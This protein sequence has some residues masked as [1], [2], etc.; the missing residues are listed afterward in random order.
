M[1]REMKYP[2]RSLPLPSL[3]GFRVPRMATTPPLREGD[4]ALLERLT[5]ELRSSG[6]IDRPVAPPPEQSRQEL[7]SII[8]EASVLAKSERELNPHF[9]DEDLTKALEDQV[10]KDWDNPSLDGIDD[11]GVQFYENELLKESKDER[12]KGRNKTAGMQIPEE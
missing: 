5:Q 10:D 8:E 12:W 11:Y 4:K 2:E 7:S 1:P 3:Q 6:V 9:Y